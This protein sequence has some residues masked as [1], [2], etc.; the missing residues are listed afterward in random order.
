MSTNKP[1]TPKETHQDLS[2]LHTVIKELLADID[3]LCARYTSNLPTVDRII[4]L[5]TVSKFIPLPKQGYRKSRLFVSY[6]TNLI[7]DIP[8]IGQCTLNDLIGW[9]ELGLPDGSSVALSSKLPI[10]M[11]YRLHS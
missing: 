7:F 10:K 4:T 2:R 9:I 8:G 11:L 6:P 1:I 5:D 3:A